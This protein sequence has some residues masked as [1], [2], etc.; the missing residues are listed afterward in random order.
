MTKHLPVMRAEVLAA[1]APTDGGLYV[2]CTFG[3][4][5]HSRAILTAADCRVWALDRDQD[6]LKNGEKLAARSGG[7]LALKHGRF[8]ELKRLLAED[9]IFEAQGI[10]FDLG[11]SSDQLL[12][13]ER[14]FSFRLKANLDMRM[15]R[16]QQ[17]DARAFINEA[18]VGELETTLRNYG[19]EKRARAIAR[20]IVKNRPILTTTR[21]AELIASLTRKRQR[22]HPA[23]RSFQAI[24]ILIN[25]E[26]EELA[27]AL[28]ASPGLLAA[29]GRLAVI[30]FHSLEDR[31][32]KQFMKQRSI[33]PPLPSRHLP[34][35]P[36]TA[37]EPV[38]RLLA[39]K[40]LTPSKAECS[41]NPA[42]RS[43]KLR[44]AEKLRRAA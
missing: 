28:E 9:R 12:T 32:V 22:I 29:G 35:R 33:P 15:D 44:V 37:A 19:E 36:E 7:R 17:F 8:S 42:A 38:L 41:A 23:T 34:L 2:D 20:A 6:A 16:G 25:N 13:V 11:P 40:P 3:G 10:L 30:S 43:A 5:G 27:K 21:L 31:I 24:R 1:L 39:K 4:G 18:A 26:L 14:G